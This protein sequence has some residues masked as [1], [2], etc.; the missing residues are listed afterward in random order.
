MLSAGFPW[1]TT[2]IAVPLVGAAI[3]WALPASARAR[4]RQIALGV[5]LVELAGAVGAAL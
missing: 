3:V 4:S 1:L 5:S 2:L